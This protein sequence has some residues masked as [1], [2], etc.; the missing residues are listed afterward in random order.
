MAEDSSEHLGSSVGSSDMNTV[1]WL[2]IM[3][4]LLADDRK[5][6]AVMM[7]AADRIEKLEAS[8]SSMRALLL[9]VLENDEFE[10]GFNNS[11]LDPEFK[12]QIREA[13]AWKV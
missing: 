8:I 10:E 2:R 12:Q 9:G 3:A 5:S 11:N 4:A 7:D 1:A 13:V 6:H